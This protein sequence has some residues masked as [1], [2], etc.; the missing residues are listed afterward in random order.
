MADIIFPGEDPVGILGATRLPDNI[1]MEFWRG[2]QQDFEIV[3]EN[4][5]G[6]PIDLTGATATATIRQTFNSPTTYEFD[7][8]IHDGNQVSLTLTSAT[9]A[10]IPGGEYIWNFQITFFNGAVRTFLAGDVTVFE[11]VD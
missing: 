2:D 11:D 9:S 3:L 5:D 1:D 10:T 8:T 4:E 6:T 7:C